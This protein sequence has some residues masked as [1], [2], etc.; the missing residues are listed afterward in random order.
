MCVEGLGSNGSRPATWGYG[1]AAGNGIEML[2]SP[3]GL[4]CQGS[5]KKRACHSQL[6]LE[7]GHPTPR[8]P[9]GSGERLRIT[10]AALSLGKN[11]RQS[12]EQLVATG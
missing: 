12:G 5:L 7:L 11:W 4:K 2:L 8:H 9:G 6:H 10:L 3:S 1:F